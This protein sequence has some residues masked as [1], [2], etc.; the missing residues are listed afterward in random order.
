MQNINKKLENEKEEYE[1]L[2]KLNEKLVDF[3][4][5]KKEEK[6]KDDEAER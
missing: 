5:R 6:Q 3:S 1:I 4:K 2:R